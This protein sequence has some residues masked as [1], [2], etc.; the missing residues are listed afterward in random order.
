MYNKTKMK[1]DIL[2]SVIDLVEEFEL[3]NSLENIYPDDIEGFKRW[4]NVKYNSQEMETEPYWE[5]KES[6]RSAESVIS[7]LIVHMNRYAKSYSKSAIYG[8]DFSSQEDFIYL[9]NL[10]AFGEMTKMDLI[11]KNVHEKPAG[12]QII[13]R[14]ISQGW[15]N[16]TDSEIDKRSKVLKISF[17][18]LNVLEN[19]MDRIRKATEIVTGDLNHPEK[20]ELIKLLNKLN[21]FHQRIYYKNIETEYLLNEALKD[22]RR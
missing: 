2:K 9:I 17:K 15:V 8:S 12:M 18:G 19:Q 7:T 10:K 6:G 1:Y 4:I 5:G 22:K 16:Q 3:E 20:M 13:N 11:K 21:K 14:L